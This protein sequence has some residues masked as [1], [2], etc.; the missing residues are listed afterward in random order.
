M[1]VRTRLVPALDDDDKPSQA[2]A[3][4]LAPHAVMQQF[5]VSENERRALLT[6]AFDN[7]AAHY[8][9]INRLMSFGTDGW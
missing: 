1:E 3:T 5:Y 8:D 6:R 9:S 7:T 2:P 4:A